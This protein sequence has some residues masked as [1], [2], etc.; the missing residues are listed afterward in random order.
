[1]KVK[2]CMFKTLAISVAIVG[3]F[4]CGGGGGG[5]A[6][7]VTPVTPTVIRNPTPD[8]NSDVGLS[9]DKA[10]VFK[11]YSNALVSVNE[12]AGMKPGPVAVFMHGCNGF[13]YD[14]NPNDSSNWGLFL[15]SQGYTVI[16]PDSLVRPSR[17]G[18]LTCDVATHTAGLNYLL[19][20]KR[21]EEAYYALNKVLDAAWWDNK[22]LILGG[23]S[24]GGLTVYQ[25]EYVGPTHLIISG[26][27]CN[28]N[29]YSNPKQ[30]IFLLNG[31]L[32]PWYYPVL[33]TPYTGANCGYKMEKF[34]LFKVTEVIIPG[35]VHNGLSDP[36]GRTA[37]EKFV[38]LN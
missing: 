24:E 19:Y 17:N 1:M 28:L 25:R 32:D 35:A 38:K 27:W 7:P 31:S 30:E 37:A 18:K 4:G 36:I 21:I 34:G 2:F 14:L 26:Y 15:A 22:R 10:R 6:S 20:D 3:L 8:A 11:P 9:W 16:M 13:G 33:H 12:L 5:G 23:E 29:V